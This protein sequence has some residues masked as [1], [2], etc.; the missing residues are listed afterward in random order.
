MK[1]TTTSLWLLIGGSFLLSACSPK[2][3]TAEYAQEQAQHTYKEQV[4]AASEMLDSAPSWYLKPPVASDA[5]YG[6]A[7]SF[8]KDL[9]FSIE[10]ACVD[11]KG[12]IATQLSDKVTMKFK[13]FARETGTASDPVLVREVEKVA[14]ELVNDADIAGYVIEKK[15][16]QQ[17]A[18]GYR[19]FVLIRYPLGEAN[20][21]VVEKAKHDALL[22]SKVRESKA[23]QELES[24]VKTLKQS[25]QQANSPKL[26]HQQNTVMPPPADKTA[27]IPD[28]PSSDINIGT[29][30]PVKPNTISQ[31]ELMPS[32]PSPPSVPSKSVNINQ[33]S[34]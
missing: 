29:V 10:K 13:S 4:K 30:T 2:Y 12:D 24:E 21:V 22:E 20:R 23:F 5:L 14:S 16:V 6:V 15:E 26:D 28:A 17:Q 9:Q 1:Y 25:P 31:P 33:T 7:S 3:G 19:T 11:A 27:Q 34:L 18:N 8:S 32:N